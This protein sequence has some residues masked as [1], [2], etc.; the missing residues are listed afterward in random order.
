[1]RVRN[2]QF[3]LHLN[4]EEKEQLVKE[5]AKAGLTKSEFIR[6]K[7]ADKKINTL[8]SVNYDELY[9]KAKG[10]SNSLE[11]VL[12]FIYSSK[13]IPAQAVEDCLVEV[14][15][16]LDKTRKEFFGADKKAQKQQIKN[17]TQEEKINE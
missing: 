15:D 12:K 7:I 9:A 16:L 17:L 8:P 11:K 14:N 4:D 1:M 10:I 6:R 13:S 5:A 3:K 2:K